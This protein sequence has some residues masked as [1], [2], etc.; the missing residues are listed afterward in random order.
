MLVESSSFRKCCL[1]D[2]CG[3]AC[4]IGKSRE[5]DSRCPPFPLVTALGS[6]LVVGWREGG[7]VAVR[8]LCRLQK[9]LRCFGEAWEEEPRKEQGPLN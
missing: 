8:L 3:G 5:C 4:G 9:V 1:Q 6:G 7:H 2:G